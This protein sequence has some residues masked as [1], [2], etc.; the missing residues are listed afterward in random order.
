[1]TIILDMKRKE[2]KKNAKTYHVHETCNDVLDMLIESFIDKSNAEPRHVAMIEREKENQKIH[3]IEIEVTR[4]SHAHKKNQ[5]DIDIERIQELH[6]S[7]LS[8]MER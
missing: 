7:H 2:S 6:V 5:L 1:M 8:T 3:K 4:K